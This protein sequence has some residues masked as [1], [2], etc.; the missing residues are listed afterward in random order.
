MN[1]ILFL[2]FPNNK[3][4]SVFCLFFVLKIFLELIKKSEDESADLEALIQLLEPFEE[5]TIMVSSSKNPTAGL[6]M[7]MMA[8][9]NKSL[10][11]REE[12]STLIKKARAVILNDLNKRYTRTEER[13][14]PGLAS[15]VD[16]RF[17][18]LT[19]MS[20][21]DKAA[22]Q[23]ALQEEAM[24]VAATLRETADAESM[25]TD[26]TSAPPDEPSNPVPAASSSFSFFDED[27]LGNEEEAPSV[28]LDCL[29]RVEN[30]MSGYA[31][32][33][34]VPHARNPV[35]WWQERLGIYPILS[36]EWLFVI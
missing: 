34:K 28:E 31:K 4:L 9:F 32:E 12:D 1:F 22:T 15:A 13:R 20:N 23:S 27:I 30:E 17:K 21:D 3:D 10:A 26:S 35:A 7:P 16:P 25:D 8:Q 2:N 19:W 14:I 36:T 5:A 29:T 6:I 11:P 33:L 18:S 24:A